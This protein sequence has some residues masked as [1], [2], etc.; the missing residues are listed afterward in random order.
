M[1]V[2]RARLAV[3]AALI[4]FTASTHAVV[5]GGVQVIALPDGAVSATYEDRPVLIVEQPKPTAI[6]GIALDAALGRHVLVVQSGGDARAEIPFK[7]T[8]KAYPVQRLTLTDDKMVNPP[9]DELAR[10]ERETILQNA[11][12]DRF[13]PLAASP[14]PM[15]LP[16]AGR[17]SSNFGLRRIL[18]GQPRNPHAGLDIAAPTGAPVLAPAAGTI[19]FTGSLYF[20]GN[21]I[22]IDHGGG[23]ISMLCHLS[24]IDVQAGDAVRKS[25]RI[26]LV[27]A[28]GRATGPHLHWSVSLN[29]A[30]VDPSAVL[31]LYRP[32]PKTDKPAQ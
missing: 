23:L 17:V 19:S 28:T 29:G 27:G 4:V 10:I 22:F 7:V 21:A 30:R 6:V 5:R 3:A 16:A 18:N 11:Q 8:D 15:R 9:P 20:N 13:T 2:E 26:G 31:A 12:Y 14:F 24:K 25:Q 1:R 32:K